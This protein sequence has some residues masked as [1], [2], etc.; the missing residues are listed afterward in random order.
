MPWGAWVLAE[1][2]GARDNSL[3]ANMVRSKLR[4]TVLVRT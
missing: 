1:R 4:L 2:I 3:L